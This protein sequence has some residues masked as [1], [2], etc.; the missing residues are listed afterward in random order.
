VLSSNLDKHASI[1]KSTAR[2]T[3]DTKT[4]ADTGTSWFNFLGNLLSGGTGIFARI[5]VGMLALIFIGVGLWMAVEA[6]EE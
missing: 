1:D 6:K 5:G 3:A 2:L 4:I